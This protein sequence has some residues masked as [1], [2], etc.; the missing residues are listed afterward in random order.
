MLLRQNRLKHKKSHKREL[1]ARSLYSPRGRTYR[2]AS[3]VPRHPADSPYCSQHAHKLSRP[4][5]TLSSPSIRPQFAL[6]FSS[7]A[8]TPPLSATSHVIAGN[9]GGGTGPGSILLFR[10]PFTLT[11][12][13]PCVLNRLV[14]PPVASPRP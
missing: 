7:L 10:A 1:T 6:I 12:P 8:S 3:S 9:Q 2:K 14:S 13:L 11:V 4:F 5:R